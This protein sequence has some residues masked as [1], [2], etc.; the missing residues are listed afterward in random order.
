MLTSLKPTSAPVGKSDEYDWYVRPGDPI[1]YR[2]MC[3][4]AVKLIWGVELAVGES[5]RV[6]SDGGLLVEEH[7]VC[8]GP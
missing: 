8:Y 6:W 3:P 4:G 2:S 7:E 1:G 5:V